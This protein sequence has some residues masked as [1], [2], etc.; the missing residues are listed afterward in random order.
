MTVKSQ[1]E[2]KKPG[3]G[4][5]VTYLKCVCTCVWVPVCVHV[6]VNHVFVSS[7]LLIEDTLNGINSNIVSVITFSGY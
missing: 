4:K 5:G 6:P 3:S 1:V 7:I 2:M